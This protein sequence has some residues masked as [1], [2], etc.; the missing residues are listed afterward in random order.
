MLSDNQLINLMV[1]EP[2]WEDVIVKIVAEEGMDPWSI[3]IVRLADAFSAFAF[4]QGE[5]DLKVPARFILISAILLRM[6]SDILAAKPQ[7]IL[8][9]ESPEQ[10]QKE[11]ELLRAL[12]AIPPLQPPVKRMPLKNVTLNELIFALRKAFEVRERRTLRKTR[13]RQAA[14]RLIVKEEDITERIDNLLNN[15]KTLIEEIEQ[16]KVAFSRLVKNWERES[17]VKALIPLLHLSQA[18]KINYE[19][20]QLFEEIFVELAPKEVE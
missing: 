9:P 16:D 3:D 5:F 2:S 7:Q 17:I 6:K 19:Q 8:I 13:L 15:I 14:E 10:N 20:P 1:T 4:R 18:G 11:L 12:A